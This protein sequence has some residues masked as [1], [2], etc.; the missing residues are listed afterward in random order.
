MLLEELNWLCN[1]LFHSFFLLLDQILD[2]NIYFFKKRIIS[3][4]WN[5]FTYANLITNFR[6]KYGSKIVAPN[7]N[8]SSR[9]RSNNSNNM[10]EKVNNWFFF[11]IF[12]LEHFHKVFFFANFLPFFAFFCYWKLPERLLALYFQFSK[13]IAWVHILKPNH[14]R[15]WVVIFY[16]FGLL[17]F[18]RH[19]K[20]LFNKTIWY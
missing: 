5:L 4:T 1:L 7:T 6:L 8:E 12:D 3:T 18:L 19:Y 17:L 15:I 11:E 13:T 14:F 20:D 2:M 9:S 16:M 10:K